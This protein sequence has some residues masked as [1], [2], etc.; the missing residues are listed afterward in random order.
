LTKHPLQVS[1]SEM[2]LMSGLL[3]YVAASDRV[4]FD[5]VSHHVLL[6]LILD[7]LHVFEE[8]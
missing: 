5:R 8:L 6:A 1:V 7:Q 2:A 4:A 3:L